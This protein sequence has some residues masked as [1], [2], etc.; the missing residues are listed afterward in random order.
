MK[1]IISILVLT[2][3]VGCSASEERETIVIG[4]DC[5][6]VEEFYLKR[7]Y[8]GGGGFTYEFIFSQ[9]ITFDCVNETWGVYYP[10]SNVNY[11]TGKVVCE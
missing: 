5:N 10:V 6:C 9:P 4:E 7:P 1:R 2:F 3:L 8:V 11:N